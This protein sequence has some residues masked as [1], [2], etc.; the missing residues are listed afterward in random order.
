MAIGL[1]IIVLTYVHKIWSLTPFILFL[2]NPFQ[3]FIEY[4]IPLFV[5]LI[6]FNF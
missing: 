6:N 5:K 1:I 2:E 3:H 4:T